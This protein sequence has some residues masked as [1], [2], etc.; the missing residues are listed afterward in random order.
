MVKP[1]DALLSNGT[2]VTNIREDRNGNLWIA[3]NKGL[4]QM[5]LDKEGHP[6]KISLI[7]STDGLMDN[8]IPRN[9]IEELEDGSFLVGSAHG[10]STVP[11]FPSLNGQNEDGE[12]I[13]T[14]T[15]FKIFDKSLRTLPPPTNRT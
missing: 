2:V 5:S 11:L 7:T 13:L 10:I 12:D 8:Y 9:T 14:I 15:D 6:D 1:V 4:I 3:T